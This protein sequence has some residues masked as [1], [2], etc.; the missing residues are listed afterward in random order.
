MAGNKSALGALLTAVLAACGPSGPDTKN[1]T[2]TKS[3]DPAAFERGEDEILRDLAAIDKRFARR[4]RIEPSEYDL[5][6]VAVTAILHEDPTL[7]AGVRIVRLRRMQR[8]G[9]VRVPAAG[10]RGVRREA[11]RNGDQHLWPDGEVR[12]GRRLRE[13]G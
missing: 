8:R 4:A 5:R 6:R 11:L 2:D 12:N 7:A 3:A 13:G 1:P 9:A 10:E